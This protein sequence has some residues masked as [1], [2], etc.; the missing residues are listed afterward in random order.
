[1][2]RVLRFL[3]RWRYRPD[4]GLCLAM[5]LALVA[6]APFFTRPG[7]PRQTDAELHVY[8]A[9]ELGHA[10]RSGVLY[11]RWAP[12]LYYGYGYPIFNYYAPLT[13]YLA[14]VFD[15]LP[16]VDIV[17]GVKAVFVLG[18]LAASAGAYLLGRELFGPAP[19][20]IAAASFTFAPYI[21]FIDPHARGDL[22]EHFAICLM[23]L[24]FYAFH[25][26]LSG[27]GGR[28]AFLGG[29]LSLAAIVFSHNLLGLV[30]GML[31][32]GYWLWLVLLGGGRARAGWGLLAFTLAA[33]L[34]AFFWL[35][36]LLE[37]GAIKLDVVDSEGGHFDFHNHFLTL[38]E[39]L[40]PS[41][42]LDLG[43]TAPR[44]PYNLG[45]AQWLL[46][47]PAIA[48]I[49]LAMRRVLRGRGPGGKGILRQGDCFLF[50]SLCFF[51]SV[52]LVFVFLMLPVSTIIWE[53]VPGMRYFQFPWRFIAP[54][55]L[56]LAV[57]AAGGVFLL[58]VGRWRQRGAAAI[59][60]AVLLFSLPALYPPMWSPDFGGV[61]PQDIIAWEEKYHALGTTSTGDFLPVEAALAPVRPMPSLVESYAHPGPVDRVNRAVLPDRATVEIV[62]QRAFYDRFSVYTPKEFV[63]RL[64]I[65]Y[66]P[67]WRVYIDGQEAEIDVAGPEGFITVVMPEGAHDVLVRFEDTPPRTAGWIISAVGLAG[68]VIAVIRIP[69]PILDDRPATFN[70]RLL[71]W[72]GGALALFVLV[73][74]AVIDP[75]DGWLRYTSPPGQARAAQHELRANFGGQIELLGYDL[76]KSRVRSGE[77]LSLVLY[78]HALAPMGEN[79]QTFVHVARPLYILWG[80]VDRPNPGDF[81]TTRWPL[82]KYVWDAYE[83]RILPGT[84]PGEYVVNVGI[85]SWGGGYRLPRY[86]EGGQV[87]GDSIV[88]ST[89]E[90]LPPRRQ[91]TP[92]E[93]GMTEE[94]MA[95]F[96]GGVTLLGYAQAC[97]QVTLP[98]EWRVTLFWRAD[99]DMPSARIRELVLLDA[100]GQEVKRFSGA[101]AEGTYPFEVWRSGEVVRDPLRL[102]FTEPGDIEA[103]VYRFGV[104]VGAESPLAPDGATEAFVSLGTVEFV[105]TE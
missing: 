26:L 91:P 43:A 22:A 76:P 59:L 82:D 55:N 53:R 54:A 15:L 57:C 11:A 105:A 81:P 8:R 6:A 49:A 52:A 62:D 3:Q 12:D 67:G 40:A 95:A 86:D 80:Q 85:P 73:K 83:V 74:G 41:P 2:Y 70:L 58:Q 88:V 47:L 21:V 14:N 33:M 44:F 75:R 39:L 32:L 10:L 29:V 99:R 60:L 90:V 37:R 7:L 25:R 5:A 96:P 84:P 65:F 61:S 9:A 1:M 24:S 45:L 28:W 30:A 23:P 13:Y 97:E 16:G 103:G 72:L 19:G 78:W 17:G 104:A 18:F 20:V 34:I 77:T 92:A 98:G 69:C 93:L 64:Y 89:V 27:A 51:L 42:V 87:V 36:F 68:L 46:A 31:L 101:P 56:M 48:A 50:R 4:W 79:Y 63:F 102:V 100:E 94:M 38:G 35:P 71:F 66:F